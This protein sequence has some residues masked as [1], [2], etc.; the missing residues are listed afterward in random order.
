MPSSQSGG[1]YCRQLNE[2]DIDT[3][4]VASDSFV[5]AKSYFY[6]SMETGFNSL[7]H[8]CKAHNRE[9]HHIYLSYRVMSEGKKASP[10]EGSYGFVELIYRHL[11]TQKL[12]NGGSVFVFYDRLC[13]NDGQDWEKGFIHGLT[14][15]TVIILIISN[16]VLRVICAKAALEQD[17]VLVDYEFALLMNLKYGTPVIP[18]FVADKDDK[19]YAINCLKI[20]Y[21][22]LLFNRYTEF[23][24]KFELPDVP[25]ARN[26][27]VSRIISELSASMPTYEIDFL[28]SIK[29]TLAAIFFING[30]F[31]PY[32]GDDKD[33]IDSLVCRVMVAVQKHL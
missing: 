5:S 16:T 14:S 22:F 31:L 1:M 9:K 17:N 21:L 7:V 30:A 13:L 32:R 2:R 25:H 24:F 3:S 29:M 4:K 19:G 18:I 12:H 10:A 33:T 15:S 27:R 11:A 8:K 28:Q 6:P 23:N 20:K 26:S